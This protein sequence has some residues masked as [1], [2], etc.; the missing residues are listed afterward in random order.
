MML[1]RELIF[2]A[3]LLMATV[4]GFAADDRALRDFGGEEGL[5][6]MTEDFVNEVLKDPLL[7][8]AFKNADAERLTFLLRNQFCQLLGGPCIYKGKNMKD[9]HRGMIIHTTQFN[10]MVEDLYRVMRRRRI[11]FRAQMKLVGKLAAL[12]R[13][14]VTK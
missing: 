10:S 2:A 5:T 4:S 6:K 9:T 8:E 11:P 13:D 12:K 1:V 14:V 3:M 7:K